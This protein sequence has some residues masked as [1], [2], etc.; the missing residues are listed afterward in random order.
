MLK[1]GASARATKYR[2]PSGEARGREVLGTRDLE[3]VLLHSH[4][5]SQLLPWRPGALPRVGVAAGRAG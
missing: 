4:I 5:T 1:T 2:L 3:D